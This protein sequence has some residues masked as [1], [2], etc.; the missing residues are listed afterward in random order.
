MAEYLSKTFPLPPVWTQVK[1]QLENQGHNNNIFFVDCEF[2]RSANGRIPFEIAIRNYAGELVL[3][4]LIDYKAEI[5]DLQKYQQTHSLRNKLGKLYSDSEDGK[6]TGITIEELANKFQ[7]I[8]IN[9]DSILIEWSTQWCDWQ[10]LYNAFEL[11]SAGSAAL[12]LP[13][14]E[15][16]LRGI[17]DIWKVIMPGCPS[18]ALDVLYDKVFPDDVGTPHHGAG[19]DTRKL[20]RIVVKA[21]ENCYYR[22]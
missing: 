14:K 20:Y 9:K 7:E 15:Y 4:T 6:T 19:W 16:V 5:S 13:P 3:D 8:G 11:H 21:L 17:T 2:R 12:F 18:F 10:S 22:R 1:K